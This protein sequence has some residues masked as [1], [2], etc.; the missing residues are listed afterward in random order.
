MSY[1]HFLSHRGRKNKATV[2]ISANRDRE[3]C[4]LFSNSLHC[5]RSSSHCLAVELSKQDCICMMHMHLVMALLG[6]ERKL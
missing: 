3:D 4:P 2:D 1:K 5:H 6:L